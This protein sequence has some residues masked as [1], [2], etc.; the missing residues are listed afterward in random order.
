MVGNALEILKDRRRNTVERWMSGR[1]VGP[2]S[3]EAIRELADLQ[4]AIAA[5]E[6]VQAGKP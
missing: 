6:H 2:P 5:I 1:L 3:Q 4:N